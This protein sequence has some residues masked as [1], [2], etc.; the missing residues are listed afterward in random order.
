M[1]RLVK[2]LWPF[3]ESPETF[4][5]HF[6]WPNSL[7]IFKTKGPRGTKLQLFQ[8]LFSLQ[9][10]KKTALQSKRVGVFQIAFLARKVLGTFEKWVPDLEATHWGSSKFY[11]VEKN[12]YVTRNRWRKRF[13]DALMNARHR[14]QLEYSPEKKWFCMSSS[15]LSSVV[16]LMYVGLVCLCWLETYSL[17]YC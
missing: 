12:F 15:E 11:V 8:F 13:G 5:E 3:L 6:G 4:R 7:C 10:L 17:F 14:T 16:I 1:T 9:H 2:Q